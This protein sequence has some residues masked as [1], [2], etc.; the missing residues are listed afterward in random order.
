MFFLFISPFAAPLIS[1]I[2]TNNPSSPI[3]HIVIIMQE[4]H[5]FDNYFGTYP[6]ANATLPPGIAYQLEPVN[7]IPN[8]VCLPYGSS[9]IKPTAANSSSTP[10]P[11]EGKSA[12]ENDI[13]NGT[14]NGFPMY[15]GPQSMIYYDYH[16]IPAYW[17]YAEEYGIGDNYFSSVLSSTLP[18]RMMELFGNSWDDS[19]DLGDPSFFSKLYGQLQT[20]FTQSIMYQLSNAGVSW[21]YYDFLNGSP[22][23]TNAPFGLGA[24]VGNLSVFSNY[25]KT[26]AGLPQVSFVNSLGANGLDEI[27]PDNVT[28]GMMWTTS[29]INS[30]E[31]SNYWNS[32]AVFVTWDE[33][34]GFYDHVA[35]P[36]VLSINNNF[37]SPLVGYG[38]RVPLLVIS[39]YAK[40]NYVSNTELNHMSLL[41]FIDWNFDLP[42]L[43]QN[44]ANSNLPLDFFQ[45]NGTARAP[46]TLDGPAQFAPANTF[47]IPLQIPL[48]SLHYARTGS[49]TGP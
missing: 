8:N 35:P 43:N 9:C 16:Q 47:P 44:V 32:T 1:P 36:N 2:Q 25:V 19:T 17:D 26:G 24:N 38:Q 39:P 33:G 31:N 10:N 6:T 22:F 48:S 46:I 34:G 23:S 12:Y 27:S 45:F 41:K 7:G 28:K 49:Y 30:I 3:Q 20:T 29:V 14:M 15:S 13:H 11:T 37:T 21:G 4:N 40:E 42:P 18:N 5:S